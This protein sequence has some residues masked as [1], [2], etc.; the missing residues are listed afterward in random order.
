MPQIIKPSN[1]SRFSVAI[2]ARKGFR[3]IHLSET[4]KIKIW[5][6][7]QF[8]LALKSWTI[9]SLQMALWFSI[10]FCLQGRCVVMVQ[11]MWS[12]CFSSQVNAFPSWL[13]N[14]FLVNFLMWGHTERAVYFKCA[15]KSRKPHLEVVNSSVQ[16]LP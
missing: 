6:I 3:L 5:I 14:P 13:A 16:M 7:L 9:S 8:V 1:T 2:C 15:S 10:S 12:L 11:E 4:D